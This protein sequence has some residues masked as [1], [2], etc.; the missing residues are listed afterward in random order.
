MTA[1]LRS[2]LDAM[3]AGAATRAQVAGATG[4]PRDVVDAALD[5]LV[6]AGRLAPLPLTSSC[7]ARG[8]SACPVARA[9]TP[10]LH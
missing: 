3:A 1:P 6:R 5:H 9:C 7:P 4:L 2:V 8:C 10:A